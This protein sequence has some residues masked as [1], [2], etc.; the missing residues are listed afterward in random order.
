MRDKQTHLDQLCQA[1]VKPDHSNEILDDIF[2]KIISPI[3]ENQTESVDCNF[4]KKHL[5]QIMNTNKVNHFD[6]KPL[7]VTRKRKNLQKT[8][9]KKIRQFP[10]KHRRYKS[11]NNR[12]ILAG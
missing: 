7:I 12:Y 3:K 11:H 4:L 2:S 10:W 5:K 6:K 1:L 9:T 8:L